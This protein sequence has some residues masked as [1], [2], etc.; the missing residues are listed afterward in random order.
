MPLD[1]IIYSLEFLNPPLI[2]QNK[3]SFSFLT[4]FLSSNQ[5]CKR[6]KLHW[7][8]IYKIKHSVMSKMIPRSGDWMYNAQWKLYLHVLRI[9]K[10]LCYV[11]NKASI[12][13]LLLVV[14]IFNEGGGGA[15]RLIDKKRSHLNQYKYVNHD[16][17]KRVNRK[18]IWFNLSSYYYTTDK[19]KNMT[20]AFFTKQ[21][22][23]SFVPRL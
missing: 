9:N 14:L 4:S 22:N 18:K 17:D 10:I 2:S 7:T 20:R 11:L 8:Y 1:V 16:H 19:N 3:I 6:V 21:R 13:Y 23:S 5:W 15:F 12:L